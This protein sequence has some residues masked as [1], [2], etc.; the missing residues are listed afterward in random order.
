MRIAGAALI[1]AAIVGQL[2]TSY[3]FWTG[4]PGSPTSPSQVINFVS[5]FTIDSNILTVV[6]FLIGAVLPDQGRVARAAL[7]PVGRAA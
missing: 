7:V 4:E 5:F 1:V 3:A 2:I 6:V